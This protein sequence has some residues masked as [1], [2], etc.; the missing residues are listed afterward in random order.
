M[1]DCIGWCNTVFQPVEAL[2]KPVEATRN[3]A[4][5]LKDNTVHVLNWDGTGFIRIA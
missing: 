3:H 1:M 5:I 2:P 4:Y